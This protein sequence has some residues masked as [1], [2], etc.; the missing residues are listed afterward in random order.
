VGR[1]YERLGQ[2][3]KAVDYFRKALAMRP[4]DH[5]AKEGLKR[6]AEHK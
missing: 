5:L 3:Q 6:A 4:A 1:T 2:R